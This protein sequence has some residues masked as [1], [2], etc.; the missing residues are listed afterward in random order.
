MPHEVYDS[1]LVQ[2]QLKLPTLGSFDLMSI[3]D[4]TVINT[5]SNPIIMGITVNLIEST[6]HQKYTW[7]WSHGHHSPHD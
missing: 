4:S 7:P 2:C 6:F 1:T 3:S 5:T